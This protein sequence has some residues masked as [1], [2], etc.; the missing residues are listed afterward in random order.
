MLYQRSGMSLSLSRIF[1]AIGKSLLNYS[2]PL[3][4]TVFGESVSRH[5]TR[6]GSKAVTERRVFVSV[7]LRDKFMTTGLTGA[8]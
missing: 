4:S 7:G 8:R 6:L 5:P 2:Q 3:F 1:F